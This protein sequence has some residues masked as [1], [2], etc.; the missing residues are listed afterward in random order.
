M[1]DGPTRRP[2]IAT[3]REILQ[4]MAALLERID[5]RLGA[6]EAASTFGPRLEKL[7]DWRILA[8]GTTS[9]GLPVRIG[10]IESDKTKLHGS[11]GALRWATGLAATGLGLLVGFVARGGQ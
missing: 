10:T 2:A 7:E 4:A 11:V 9:G 1:R 6:I 5:E 3:D 8:D